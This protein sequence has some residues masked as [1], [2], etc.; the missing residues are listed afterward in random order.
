MLLSLF[1][2]FGIY[3][4]YSNVKSNKCLIL[5][6]EEKNIYIQAER[7]V[8][9]R[10]F[11]NIITMANKLGDG[12]DIIFQSWFILIIC[13]V[14][15]VIIKVIRFHQKKTA[16]L[17][18]EQVTSASDFTLMLNGLPIGSYQ[19]AE[20]TSFIKKLWE[21]IAMQSK[22]KSECS[23]KK[24]VMAY[25]LREFINALKKKGELEI[26]KKKLLKNSQHESGGTMFELQGEVNSILKRWRIYLLQKT[27]NL[28]GIKSY[29]SLKDAS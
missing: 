17:C 19:E 25:D 14:M 22:Q 2:L 26:I 20:I 27:I 11:L 8:C 5:N 18:D 1:F 29:F 23:I 12:T 21:K 6:E 3:A 4:T 24:I 28:V 16:K 15:D 10:A 7:R 13:V 9:E